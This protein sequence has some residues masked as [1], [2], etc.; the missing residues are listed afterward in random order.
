MR[1]SVAVFAALALVAVM[2]VPAMAAKPNLTFVT[3]L[4]QDGVQL[5]GNQT[6]GFVIVTSGTPGVQYDLQTTK[7]KA[8]PGVVNGDYPFYLKASA[9]QQASLYAYFVAKGW[10]QVY[11]DQIAKEIS[12]Q[13]SFFVI[14]VGGG[15]G[16]FLSDGFRAALM[17]PGMYGLTI[18]ADYPLGS[19]TYSGR[20]LGTNGVSRTFSIVMTVVRG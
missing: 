12:G 5:S 2:A 8:N 7:T 10:P 1:R 20:L 17:P 19:Y 6:S 14:N 18:D 16:Y 9:A 15:N 4:T 3:H 13:A 11:L